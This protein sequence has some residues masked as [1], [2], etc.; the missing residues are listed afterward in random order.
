MILKILGA[1]DL[2]AALTFLMLIFR[3]DVLSQ[4]LLFFG[5]LLFAK[6]LFVI[7]G[8]IL[9]VIDLFSSVLLILSLFFSIAVIFL[10]V[11]AFLLLAKGIVSFY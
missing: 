7:G 3:Y 6:G 2:G 8:D 11:F 9:S 4:L 5:I 10:W 1:I